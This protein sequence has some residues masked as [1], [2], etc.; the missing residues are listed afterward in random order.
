MDRLRPAK[1]VPLVLGV[2]LVG[3]FTCL[4]FW[5]LDRAAGKAARYAAFEAA[6]TQPAVTLNRY[7]PLPR[8][9]PVTINGALHGP[10]VFLDNQLRDGRPGV[11]VFALLAPDN[12]GPEVLVNLGWRPI[13]ARRELPEVE[14]PEDSRVT[15]LLADPP[16]VG[17][18]LGDEA[19]AGFGP[20]R[21]PYL[22][23]A[24]L[25]RRLK[26]KL[27]PQI[28]LATGDDPEFV[29][30]WRPATMPPERHHAYAFQWFSL[31]TAVLAIL[32]I[33]IWR[34]RRMTA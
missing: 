26:L 23:L 19:L 8:Y 31:A 1:C 2:V 21:T 32:S 22:E 18:K 24:V 6:K 20:L 7:Q 17:I 33:G 11:H 12:G 15:G 5:Q 13:G 16:P 27:A 29:R 14:L 9:A 3:L 10:L 34:S 25:E 28:L 4:G 30:Q